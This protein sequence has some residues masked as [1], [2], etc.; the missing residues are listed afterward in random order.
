M[1]TRMSTCQ[2]QSGIILLEALVAFLILTF[3]TVA[4]VKIQST[5]V[6][7]HCSANAQAQ[8]YLYAASEMERVRALSL[9]DYCTPGSPTNPIDTR[10]TFDTDVTGFA[11]T[12]TTP[13]LSGLTYTVTI[14]STA[15]QGDVQTFT[16]SSTIRPNDPSIFTSA[17]GG[18][19]NLPSPTVAKRINDTTG[20]ETSTINFISGFNPNVGMGVEE[21]DGA[22]FLYEKNDDGKSY[23]RI[24][25][26]VNF[27]EI[28]GLIISRDDDL[29][30]VSPF[31]QLLTS[32][33]GF[34]KYPLNYSDPLSSASFTVGGTPKSRSAGY[35]CYVPEGWYGNINVRSSVAKT[36]ACPDDPNSPDAI[37]GFRSIRSLLLNGSSIIGQTGVL[38]SD[39]TSG[40]TSNLNYI[41][42]EA[43]NPVACPTVIENAT[44]SKGKT[45]LNYITVVKDE[46]IIN[47]QSPGGASRFSDECISRTGTQRCLAPADYWVRKIDSTIV[48]LQ[49]PDTLAAPT[50]QITSTNPLT[51]FLTFDCLTGTKVD[52]P[53]T[54]ISYTCPTD[55]SDFNNTTLI[56]NPVSSWIFTASGTNTLTGTALDIALDDVIPFEAKP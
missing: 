50:L 10:F 17:S 36:F 11:S 35:I 20:T 14:N 55:F 23:K 46:L 3:G 4:A 38:Q 5:L 26:N 27:V 44:T 52:G 22:F 40:A 32:A 53:P 33:V 31:L 15:C 30:D 56:I 28:S 29:S 18:G 43:N 6:Q 12:C 39:M 37:G 1:S 51:G 9:A 7:S 2:R 13:P 41:I 54:T 49:A 24:E 45:T 25:S 42:Y 16:F 34:C 48:T 21:K 47:K 19:N 8:A